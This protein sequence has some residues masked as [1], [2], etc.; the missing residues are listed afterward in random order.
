M[1]VKTQAARGIFRIGPLNTGKYRTAEA[2]T[3]PFIMVGQKWAAIL[4]PGE[5]GLASSVLQA[6]E[7][8][9]IPRDK[10]AYIFITHIHLHHMEGINILLDVLPQAKVVVHQRAVPHLI[11]PSRV[12]S[13]TDQIWGTEGGN[14]G[15][16]NPVK[17][18]RIIGCTGGEIID[19]GDREIEILDGRGHAPH[20]ICIFDRLTRAI[21]IGDL[22]GAIPF[23]SERGGP[24]ILP[25]MF[26]V[27]LQLESL[28]RCRALKPSVILT[29]T[30]YGG[31]SYVPD[32]TMQIAEDE[33][34]AVERVCLEGMKKKLTARQIGA[35]VAELGGRIRQSYSPLVKPTDVETE[36]VGT[37]GRH[38]GVL[39]AI[40]AEQMPPFGMIAYLK[41]EHPEL[42]WPKGMPGGEGGG[43]GL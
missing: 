42:E 38:I 40:A 6:A 27:K 28:H 24:D 41:R 18:E 29:H 5:D 3:S 37:S 10:I 22:C 25:P 1:V 33:V 20:Q 4:E 8:I 26:D 17:P 2:P 36:T 13:S 16:L 39:T 30:G 21:W 23:A 12:N 43:R 7:E 31:V 14:C 19:L 32:L 35:K 34:L 11:D 15:H 9:G